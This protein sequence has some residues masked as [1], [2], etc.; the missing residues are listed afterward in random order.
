MKKAFTLIELIFV[1]VIIGVLA[2]VAVPKFA[3]LSDSAKISSELSTA[4]SV[5]T[6]LDDCHGEW[7]VNEGSFTCGNIQSTSSDFNNTS[8]YPT[9]L[10]SHLEKI[11][12]GQ[13]V[14]WSET[15]TTN[16]VGPASNSDTG[17]HKC[18]SNKPCI[19]KHWHYDDVN[20]TFTL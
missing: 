4:S 11:L 16:Y 19:G 12:K 20:G 14:N 7:I 2:S 5:Q 15:N 13:P 9:N 18:R 6:A 17:V 3:G 8:G 1:I 10:G